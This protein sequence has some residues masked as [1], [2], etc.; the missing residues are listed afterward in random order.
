M[1]QEFTVLENKAIGRNIS[2]YRK[3]RGIKAA[4][5]AEQLGMKEAAYTKHERG[6]TNITVEFVQK[7]A[8]VLKV[9]PLILLAVHPGSMIESGN[10]SPNS[11]IALHA[12][13]C[14]TTNDEQT[15]LMLKLM[16]NVASIS[17]RLIAL[18]DKTGKKE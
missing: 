14:Q 15:K 18:L 17:D 11:I 8:E 1:E 12:H 5:I 13:N 2:M 6:E 16:E 7:V 4:D 3:I 9:D 10:N